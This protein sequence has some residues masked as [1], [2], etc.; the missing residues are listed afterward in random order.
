MAALKDNTKLR[1][2]NIGDNNFTSAGWEA[3]GKAVFDKT[4]LNSAADSNHTCCID[5]PEDDNEFDEVREIN[6]TGSYSNVRPANC[7]NPINVKQKKI[8]H[9]ISS[10]NRSM[11]NVDHFDEDMPVELLPHIL[12]T[13]ERYS[14]YYNVDAES[15]DDA[16]LQD[17]RDV[18]PLSIMFE[19]LQRW[20]KSLAAFEALSS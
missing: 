11:S 12:T 13:I 15:E 17:S 9:V 18:K 19:I 8:Y 16:P 14:S 5:F 1:T 10:R 2:L 3:L 6:G 4:S 7:F 20:D